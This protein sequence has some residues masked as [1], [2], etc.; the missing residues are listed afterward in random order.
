MRPPGFCGARWLLAAGVIA[1]LLFLGWFKYANFF[2]DNLNALLRVHW[3]IGHVL[4]PLGISFFTFMQIAWLVAS[5]RGET[6]PCNLFGYLLYITFF[7]QVVSGPIVYQRETAGQFRV[8]RDAAERT[9][10]FCVGTTLFLMGLC[11]KVLVADM[12]APWATDVFAAVG[13]G[14]VVTAAAAWIGA[15]SYT[16]QL[17]YDFSGYSDMAI[18]V[19]RLFGIR[20]PVNF[21][22]PYKATGISD[23]WRRWHM[24]LSRF[25]RDYL[26]IPLGGNRCGP[27][28]RSFNLFMTM[29]LGGLWHGA[30]WTFLMWGAL[31]GAYLVINHTWTSWRGQSANSPG[32]A[33]I[34]RLL[35]FLAVMVAWIFFRAAQFSDGWM[36]LRSMGGAGGAGVFTRADPLFAK[37]VPAIQSW[38]SQFGVTADPQMVMCLSLL[39][40]FVA[41]WSFPNSQQILLAWQ[42]ALPTYGK[43]IPPFGGR[44]CALAWRPSL[45]WL[46]LSVAVLC[47]C[48]LQMTG[49]SSFLYFDF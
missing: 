10:D 24:T 28:R 43:S 4:L 34:A 9:S 22:S 2:A 12:I 36:L 3:E 13:A 25:L 33:W 45:D 47:W 26:Y 20:L 21:H 44:M 1:N 7:P 37:S 5:G 41:V 14:H 11:K 6:V 42:P 39:V 23:F 46:L 35:T 16:F 15:L 18:G 40:L 27:V 38:V 19:A 31:H 32:G 30:G 49:V 29:V 48:L 8:R 17:Y